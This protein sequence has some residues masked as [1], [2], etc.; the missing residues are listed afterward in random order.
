MQSKKIED[1]NKMTEILEAD[2]LLKRVAW[3]ICAKLWRRLRRARFLR[4][5][6]MHIDMLLIYLFSVLCIHLDSEVHISMHKQLL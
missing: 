6:D 4:L 1:C 5:T 3:L 2:I